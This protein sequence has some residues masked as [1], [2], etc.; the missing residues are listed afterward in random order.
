MKQTNSTFSKKKIVTILVLA[1]ALLLVFFLFKSCGSAEDCSTLE[2]R[3]AF[4]QGLGW[5]IDLESEDVRTVQLPDALTGKLEDYNQMQLAQGYDLSRHLGEQ[6][7]QYTYLVV[8][9][10]DQSQTVL[11]TVYVQ[12]SRVIAGDIHS[13]ALNG[14]MHG[15]KME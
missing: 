8:N 13:T 1:A 12:G 5:E 14:F 10:P 6:C 3:Q 4:L 2:G 7:T 15:L 9:Y 11:A